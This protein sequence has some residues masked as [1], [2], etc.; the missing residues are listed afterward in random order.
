MPPPHPTD[1]VWDTKKRKIQ[2]QRLPSGE[3]KRFV[4]QEWDTIPLSKHEQL[5]SCLLQKCSNFFGN[6][7]WQNN[8]IL[9]VKSQVS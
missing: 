4:K 7:I 9:V 2:Q 8:I 1:N 3:I 6:W 5:V